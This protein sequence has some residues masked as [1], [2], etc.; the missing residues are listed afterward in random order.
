[1]LINN[2]ILWKDK[3]NRMEQYRK[4]LAYKFPEI[5]LKQLF[6]VHITQI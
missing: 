5:F 6:N 1:M 2:R 3:E 4:I